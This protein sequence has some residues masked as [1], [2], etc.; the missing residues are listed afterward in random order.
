MLLHVFRIRRDGKRVAPRWLPGPA[1]GWLR[2]A[3][4]PLD[5]RY[6]QAYLVEQPGSVKDVIPPL[7]RARIARI[8]G[9]GMHIA[10]IEYLGRSST[11]AKA[12]PY[13]Q[14]WLCVAAPDLAQPMLARIAAKH[15]ASTDPFEDDH[16]DYIEPLD[17]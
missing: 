6:M 11:K 4:A 8:E 13:R 2:F 9:G 1:S 16:D 10:G 14:S 3:P 12:L 7:H 5:T 15:A 17:W